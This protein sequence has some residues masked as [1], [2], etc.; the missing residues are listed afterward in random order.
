MTKETFSQ[1]LE[2]LGRHYTDLVRAHG[3]EPG[4]AQQTDRA[5]QERRMEILVEIADLSKATIFDFGCGAGH[6]LTYLKAYHSFQG[7][8]IGGDLTEEILAVAK[9][10]H[11]EARFTRRDVLA[12]GLEEEVDFA[13][14]SGTFNNRITN[15]WGFLTAALRA[16][17]SGVRGGVSFNLLSR[18][19][20]YFDDGLYYADPE[21]V[22][23]FCKEELSPRVALRHDYK[24]KAGVLPYEFT[25]YV[26]RD[27]SPCRRKKTP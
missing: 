9:K 10:S 16:L 27:D 2:Q 6:L 17:Y 24:I 3:T 4:G 23:R 5:T 21:A 7:K 15:N 20:D 19:V 12:H 1:D 13:L 25:V 18:Y 8:Y 26:Y 11:P 22:F 14:V